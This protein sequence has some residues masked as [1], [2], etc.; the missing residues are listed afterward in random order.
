MGKMPGRPTGGGVN[1]GGHHGGDATR[2]NRPW[3]DV[4]SDVGVTCGV[5]WSEVGVTC[6]VTKWLRNVDVK[7]WRQKELASISK[8]TTWGGIRR[9][10]PRL[11][12][13]SI[14][15]DARGDKVGMDG[16]VNTCLHRCQF[17]LEDV[18][19]D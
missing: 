14:P 7:A 11:S 10:T 16:H 9:W 15:V 18:E 5:T 6:G 13:R 1:D 8:G 4:R 12:E 19:V 2:S 17:Y 3:D